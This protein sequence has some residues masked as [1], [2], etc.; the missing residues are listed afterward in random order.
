MEWSHIVW[1]LAR[2]FFLRKM[3]MSKYEESSAKAPQRDQQI[4]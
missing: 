3:A 1:G 4:D 2:H